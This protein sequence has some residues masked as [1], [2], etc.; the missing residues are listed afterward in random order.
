MDKALNNILKCFDFINGELIIYLSLEHLRDEEGNELFEQEYFSYKIKKSGEDFDGLYNLKKKINEQYQLL[1]SS[2]KAV[3]FNLLNNPIAFDLFCEEME[4]RIVNAQNNFDFSGESVRQKNFRLIEYNPWDDGFSEESKD[5]LNNPIFKN[6]DILIND[7]SKSEYDSLTNFKSGFEGYIQNAK[8]KVGGLVL[9]DKKIIPNNNGTNILSQNISDV[10]TSSSNILT[11]AEA[12]DIGTSNKATIFPLKWK[13]SRQKLELVFNR[14][15]QY[16]FISMNKEG[17]LTMFMGVEEIDTPLKWL[18]DTTSFALFI[19]SFI[20]HLEKKDGK[21]IGNKIWA[22]F[23][24]NRLFLDSK[25]IPFSSL[26]DYSYQA[27]GRTNRSTEDL[28]MV[29]QSLQRL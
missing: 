8:Q 24:N 9:I 28:N 1:R 29:I 5:K 26:S 19:K 18:R 7:I 21:R 13:H 10:S 15:T 23:E 14:L 4:Q 17:F 20:K 16:G 22:F 2:S 11:P 12:Q 6:I 25:N 3:I 27:S